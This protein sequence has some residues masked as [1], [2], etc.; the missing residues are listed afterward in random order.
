MVV[1]CG[2]LLLAV[3]R[4]SKP[5]KYQVLSGRI[6]SKSCLTGTDEVCTIFYLELILRDIGSNTV[7]GAHGAHA[8]N[9]DL[10]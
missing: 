9:L 5:S 8:I 7:K 3:L 1:S 2:R 4:P 10:I 6:V